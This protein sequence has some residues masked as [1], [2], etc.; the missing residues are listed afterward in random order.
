MYSS[1]ISVNFSTCFGWYL[2]PPSGAHITVSIVSGINETDTATCRE[3]ESRLRQVAVS[4]SLMPDTIDI[5]I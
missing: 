4:V 2:H 3:R 5:V 1:F